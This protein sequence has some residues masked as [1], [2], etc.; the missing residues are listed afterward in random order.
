MSGHRSSERHPRD[1]SRA[2]SSRPSRSSGRSHQDPQRQS[3]QQASSSHHAVG[4]SQQQSS[5]ETGPPLSA[6]ETEF[7]NYIANADRR[8]PDNFSNYTADAQ[9]GSSYPY[10]GMPVMSR[11]TPPGSEPVALNVGRSYS[12]CEVCRETPPVDWTKTHAQWK[13]KH[14]ANTLKCRVEMASVLANTPVVTQAQE[15]YLHGQSFGDNHDYGQVPPPAPIPNY[16]SMP[17]PA[18]QNLYAN[19][20]NPP[21]QAQQ[22]QQQQ[23][24]QQS[25]QQQYAQ[26]PQQQQYTQEPQQQQ[27][28]QQPPT[29]QPV[30]S[31]SSYDILDDEYDD[32]QRDLAAAANETASGP[33]WGIEPSVIVPRS[34]YPSSE[35]RGNRDSGRRHRR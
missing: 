9:W 31:Q 3:H 13:R 33:G 17:P 32:E 35:S 22:S 5:P 15:E 4:T 24:T 20:Q 19:T 11:A 2:S 28:T 6:N 34:A 25:Q 29:I 8:V 7:N 30:F 16:P 27:Y 12:H 10:T 1:S 18:A 14:V 26:Q 21:Q 23:Y